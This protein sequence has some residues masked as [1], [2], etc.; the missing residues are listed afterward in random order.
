MIYYPRYDNRMWKCVSREMCCQPA[1]HV[2]TTGTVR[3]A[4]Q[5]DSTGEESTTGSQQE[6]DYQRG[7]RCRHH[8]GLA[9]SAQVLCYDTCC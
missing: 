4:L 7:L 5:R 9:Q 6:A 1:A 2:R 8:G 3:G